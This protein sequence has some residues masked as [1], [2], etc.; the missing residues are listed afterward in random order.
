MYSPA[1]LPSMQRAA[2]AK[3]RSWSTIGGTSSS[4]VVLRGLPASSDSRSA[5][6]SPRSSNASAS[7]SSIAWRS[8][9]VVFSQSVAALRAA[10]TAL[11]TSSLVESGALAITSP[12]AGLVTSSISP[13]AGS[14]NL[15]PIM[16]LSSKTFALD[17]LSLVAVAIWS[18]LVCSFL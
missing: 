2:P 14:A 16:F 12:F 18:L 4:S 3:K 15:P 13:S 8:P 6:S 10:L 11:S 17:F 9:G 7:F 5:I 1:A